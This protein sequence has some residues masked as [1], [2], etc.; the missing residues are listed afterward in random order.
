MSL[1]AGLRRLDRRWICL[2]IGLLV[3]VPLLTLPLVLRRRMPLVSF[4]LVLGT[5]GKRV[6]MRDPD[7]QRRDS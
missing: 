4:V 1:F 6:R 3:V 2:A 5:V 7:L